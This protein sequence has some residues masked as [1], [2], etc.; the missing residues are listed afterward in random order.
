MKALLDQFADYECWA[1]SLFVERLMQ[2]PD[3]VLDRPVL[4]SFPS[5]RSTFLHIR[6]ADS[7][8]RSRL[9]GEPVT[10]P[11]EPGKGL[12]TIMPHANALRDLVHGYS[13][14]EL[15]AVVM[16]RDL[17]GNEHR[18][19]RWHMLLHC[20]NHATKHRGQLITIMRGLGL[21]DVPVND[22]VMYQ[23]SLAKG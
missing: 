6:D 10:W 8:W 17:R 11:A 2:E 19:A 13:E 14:A 12:S 20:F 5:L 21:D 18:Q 7:A 9:L 23:R 16:Y 1:D 4:S 22:L 3:E 15:E